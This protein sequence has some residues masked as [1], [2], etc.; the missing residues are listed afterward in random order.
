[1]NKYMFKKF[2]H[3]EL[4]S[5]R[6]IILL[7]DNDKCYKF[8]LGK[9]LLYFSN[10]QK[11]EIKFEDFIEIYA[12]EIC[13]HLKIVSIQ[14]TDRKPPGKVLT[15]CKSFID[16]IIKNDELI[17]NIKKDEWV[18][19]K[20]FHLIKGEHVDFKYF[21]LKKDKS[22]KS[23][24]LTDSLLDLKKNIQFENLHKE[25]DGRWN[26]L[27]RA[28][29]LKIPER[30]LLVENDIKLENLF[31]KSKDNRI[32]ITGSRNALNG[33]QEGRCF[34]CKSIISIESNKEDTSDVDHFFP[35]SLEEKGSLRNLNG[36]WNLVLACKTCNRGEGGKFDKIPHKSFLEKLE[37]R[38]NALIVGHKPLRQAL[39]L[40]TGDTVIKRQK[41]L[42]ENFKTATEILY[43]ANWK[44]KIFFEN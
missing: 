41:F 11:T 30:L 17:Q 44:P 32:N 33:Y 9:T 16:G 31:I 42:A 2:T 21:D 20:K 13:E 3:D 38:N 12:T 35:Y 5:W 37:Q 40:Q 24:V 34:Y 39:I 1:M 7:G 4:S 6:S 10:L 14:G 25:V 23:I 29:Q 26:L 8:A 22:N 28:W 27:E 15:S 43:H 18:V 36:I 19:L